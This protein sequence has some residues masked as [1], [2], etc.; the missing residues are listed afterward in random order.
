M[1]H[2]DLI[3]PPTSPGR[4]Q[5]LRHRAGRSSWC[6]TLPVICRCSWRSP[7]Q[8]ARSMI[9][10]NSCRGWDAAGTE[11]SVAAAKGSVRRPGVRWVARLDAVVQGVYGQ[12]TRACADGERLPGLVPCASA[13]RRRRTASR[14]PEPEAAHGGPARHRLGVRWSRARAAARITVSAHT[15]DAGRRPGRPRRCRKRTEPPSLLASIRPLRIRGGSNNSWLDSE[16]LV[17]GKPRRTLMID[18]VCG[19]RAGIVDG[20]RGGAPQF[21]GVGKGRDRGGR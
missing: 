7:A 16:R 3:L 14:G 5:S 11:R 18:L 10:L 21:A 1:R 2:A 19:S 9:S 4:A 8:L 20:S 13:T 6:G 15:A 17:K 12:E